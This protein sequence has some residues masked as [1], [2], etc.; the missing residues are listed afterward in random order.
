MARGAVPVVPAVR[1][2]RFSKISAFVVDAR[3]AEEAGADRGVDALLG[4]FQRPRELAM[5][6]VMHGTAGFTVD[7]EVL[8]GGADVVSSGDFVEPG[9]VAGIDK[10][11]G[12][13]P[14]VG[15]RGFGA[16]YVLDIVFVK[17]NVACFTHLTHHPRQ[18]YILQFLLC[19]AATD[20]RVHPREPHL[21]EILENS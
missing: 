7:G 5:R 3:A 13:V 6:W 4:V 9:V 16:E 14:V 10:S 2:E 15:Y 17:F 19:F 11:A 21:L 8:T 18:G 1:R 20:V 12:P